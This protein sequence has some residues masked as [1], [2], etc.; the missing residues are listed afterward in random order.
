MRIFA[1]E[2]HYFALASLASS[3]SDC[4]VVDCSWGRIDFN[5]VEVKKRQCRRSR[6]LV[7]VDK[8]MV[9]NNVKQICRSPLERELVQ[10]LTIE[11]R[12]RLSDGGSQQARFALSIAPP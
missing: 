2:L 10:L 5:S 6:S 12:L 11:C 9:L 8:R 1:K 3:N 4:D 7:T